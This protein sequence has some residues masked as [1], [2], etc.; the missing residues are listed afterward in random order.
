[1]TTTLTT[2]APRRGRPA[3]T[4]DNT[5]VRE[6][7]SSYGS[8]RWEFAQENPRAE[9]VLTGAASLRTAGDTGGGLSS[10]RL[11][12]VLSGLDTITTA[13]VSE[14]LACGKSTAEAY[15]RAARVASTALAPLVVTGNRGAGYDEFSTDDPYAVDFPWV[16]NSV[17]GAGFPAQFA[18]QN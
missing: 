18:D 6:W 12:V 3:K 17:S 1:M 15:T 7:L 16:E 10:K 11:F 9:D 4:L 14:V 2:T 8:A 5:A 13:G